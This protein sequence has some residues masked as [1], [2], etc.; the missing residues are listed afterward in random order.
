MATI[1]TRG[2]RRLGSILAIDFGSQLSR[3]IEKATRE[4]A[5]I[6]ALSADMVERRPPMTMMATPNAGMKSSAARTIAVS[7]YLP[8]NCQLA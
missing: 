7:L 8:R 3:P 1:A 2:V 6:V 4:P 5:M